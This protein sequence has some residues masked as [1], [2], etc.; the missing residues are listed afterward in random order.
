[1]IAGPAVSDDAIDMGC[2]RTLS[3]GTPQGHATEV[4]DSCSGILV[5]VVA[6]SPCDAAVHGVTRFV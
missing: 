2:L 5:R 1:M 4:A 6:V 3:D